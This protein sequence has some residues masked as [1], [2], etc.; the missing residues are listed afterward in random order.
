RVL[1]LSLTPTGRTLT[2]E[3]REV[4]TGLIGQLMEDAP[5]EECMV[6]AQ[7]MERLIAVLLK[8]ENELA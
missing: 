1:R 8:D 6:V 4:Q 5:L 2:E 3:A 7:S